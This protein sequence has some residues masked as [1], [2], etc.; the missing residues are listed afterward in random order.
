LFFKR[1]ENTKE[2]VPMPMECGVPDISAPPPKAE[3]RGA[4]FGNIRALKSIN[5]CKVL[6]QKNHLYSFSCDAWWVS[7]RYLQGITR[8]TK[9]NKTMCG[10]LNSGTCA[11]PDISFSEMP[12][13][14]FMLCNVTWKYTRIFCP[15]LY[16]IC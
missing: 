9:Q 8:K 7:G 2:K 14:K 6:Q 3:L 11:H 13:K 15:V 12:H 4:Y 1:P 16:K 5:W 10:N